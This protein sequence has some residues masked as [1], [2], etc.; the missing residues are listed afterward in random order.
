VSLLE[1]VSGL[2][3]RRSTP[4]AVIGAAALATHGVSRATA[5]LDLLVI[6]ST[7]LENDVWHDLLAGGAQVDVRPG[8]REDPLAGVI[9]V[10]RRGEGAI[11]VIVGRSAWQH[12]VLARSEPRAVGGV[13]L[14][15]VRASDLVLLKLYAG[16][17]QD[18]W[19]I[20]RLLQL[21]PAI[22]SEVET[23]LVELPA[24]C[25]ELWRSARSGR[26]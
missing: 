17:P 19:D 12:G 24:D 26:A 11:D 15:V 22:A 9:R 2:L 14:P 23:R 25:A 6:D 18:V 21:D 5:D 4:H 7:C 8:D 16:G 3:R 20:D 1:E 13:T 10:V